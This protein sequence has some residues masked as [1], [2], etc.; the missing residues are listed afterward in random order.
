MV[1]SRQRLLLVAPRAAFGAALDDA[2]PSAP[3]E[4][5]EPKLK[6]ICRVFPFA[7]APRPAATPPRPPP[8]A[9]APEPPRPRPVP[10]AGTAGS[11][12]LSSR[13]IL[14]FLADGLSFHADEPPTRPAADDLLGRALADEPGWESL[15]EDD[16]TCKTWPRDEKP[17]PPWSQKESSCMPS[18][19]L[20]AE[21]RL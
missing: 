1:G 4:L 8:R 20:P 5:C 10:A 12:S 11:S 16:G 7:A 14:S 3:A 18:R 2:P 6:G 9:A 19:H 17:G 21:N 15:R 13:A